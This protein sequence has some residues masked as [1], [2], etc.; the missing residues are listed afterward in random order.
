MDSAGNLYVADNRSIRIGMVNVCG[1]RPVV[2]LPLAPVGVTRQLDT[3]PQTATAWQWSWIR[4]PAGSRAELSSTTIRNPTFTPDAPDLYVFRLLATNQVTG[5]VSLRTVELNAVP[6]NV[7]VLSSPQRLF[8]G[9]F[10]LTLIGQTNQAYTLQVSADL[11]AW[12]DWTNVPPNLTNAVM[13]S[14]GGAHSLALRADGTVVA[15]GA[16]LVDNERGGAT[17]DAGQSMVQP[18]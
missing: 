11:S 4:R 12:T 7:A 5:A 14:A 3:S 2:D 18:A 16:G 9:S 8:D 6:A 15:W 17:V 10:Q 1:D 13:V